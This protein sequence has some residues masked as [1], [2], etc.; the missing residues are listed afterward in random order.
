MKRLRRQPSSKHRSIA[1]RRTARGV[2]HAGEE[3]ANRSHRSESRLVALRHH[4]SVWLAPA[5]LLVL[6]L[7]PWPYGYYN[8]LR[9]TV[10]AVAAWIAYTQWK[11]DDAV[12]GWVVALA[13]TSILYNPVVPIYLT[14][15]I[16]SVLNLLSAGVFVGHFLALGRL[17]NNNADGAPGSAS[18]ALANSSLRPLEPGRTERIGSRDHPSK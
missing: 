4:P 18:Q 7:L 1:D 16:W 10:C 8:F 6:A 13:A 14:R 11:Q 3:A 17:V 15:E 12:S 5:G 2:A 9:L